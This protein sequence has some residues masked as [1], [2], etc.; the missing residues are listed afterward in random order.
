MQQFSFLEKKKSM[1]ITALFAGRKSLTFMAHCCSVSC[2]LILTKFWVGCVLLSHNIV[3]RT[4]TNVSLLLNNKTDKKSRILLMTMKVVNNNR[5]SIRCLG[6]GLQV[7]SICCLMIEKCLLF[8]WF[9]H[10]ANRTLCS[11]FFGPLDDAL[12]SSAQHR[13]IQAGNLHEGSV[14]HWSVP[15]TWF[16]LLSLCSRA[17]LL[18]RYRLSSV[19]QHK[20][21]RGR[22][23]VTRNGLRRT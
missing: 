13:G 2:I 15:Q 22:V 17:T 23:T 16:T 9:D 19:R 8:C 4:C 11:T 14:T 7:M 18:F 12:R 20:Q 5:S 3:N 21:T 6:I 1:N 10:I